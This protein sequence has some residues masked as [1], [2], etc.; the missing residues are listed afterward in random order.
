MQMQQQHWW[1]ALKARM[2]AHGYNARIKLT[3]QLFTDDML[4]MYQLQH[5]KDGSMPPSQCRH[6]RRCF[7]GCNVAYYPAVQALHTCKHDHSV[8]DHS[9]PLIDTRL[10]RKTRVKHRT[11]FQCRFL[12]ST[13]TCKRRHMHL[14]DDGIIWSF[15]NATRYASEP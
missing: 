12:Q 5:F 13:S 7:H 9:N 4:C 15:L 10:Q 1:R 8:N 6:G 3:A 14:I 2:K 11:T